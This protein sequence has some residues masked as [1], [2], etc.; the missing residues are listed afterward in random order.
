MD[1]LR[2]WVTEMHVD[3]FRFDLASTLARQFHDVDRLSAFF[4]LIQ[5]DPVVV[6]RQ[7]DRRAV[8]RRRGRLPGRQLPAAVVGV[9]RQVPRHVRDYWR[10]EAADAG[11][12]RLAPHRQL[13][14]LRGRRAPPVAPASTSSPRTTASRSATSSPTTRSTTRPTARA[15][16][17]ARATTARGTAGA[18]GPTD[19]PEVLDAARAAAAQLPRDAVPLA[20]HPDAARRRRDRSHAGG[21]QQRLLP[22]QR[23]LVVRLG[24]RGRRAARVHAAADRLPRARTRCSAA[25]TSSTASRWART[26]PT[27]RGS[28]PTDPR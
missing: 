13:G 4:D 8:G 22:G 9:E 10:G 23:D 28:G 6:A 14:P 15:E 18:E 21:Q 25:A 19:D 1:S 2:Y 5:Q 11:R 26:P 3:G 20:G 16:P 12:V 24:P 7:A 27:S 17:T